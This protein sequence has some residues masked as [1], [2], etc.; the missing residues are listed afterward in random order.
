MQ[1]APF[2]PRFFSAVPCTPEN[3]SSVMDCE[4]NSLIVSWSESPGADSYLATLQDSSGQ[5]TTCQGT[6]EGSCSVSGLGC[7]QIYHV[8]VISSDGY[9]DSP[10]SPVIDTPPG[11][12]E[13]ILMHLRRRNESDMNAQTPKPDMKQL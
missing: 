6:T 10:P 5:S 11:G 7:G 1:K 2:K 8:S 4:S 9:C 13:D 3:T 12:T